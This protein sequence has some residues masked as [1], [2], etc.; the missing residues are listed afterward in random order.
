MSVELPQVVH[1]AG[2]RPL[3]LGVVQAA[4]KELSQPLPVFDL[5][6]YRQGLRQFL[7][8]GLDNAKAEWSLACTVHN[9]R[10]FHA[11]RLATA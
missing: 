2:Q 5:P 1:G 11:H 4:A 8:R 7:S 10:K 9:L 6:E 3:S